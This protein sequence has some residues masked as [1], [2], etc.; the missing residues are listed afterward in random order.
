MRNEHAGTLAMIGDRL[1]G[2]VQAASIGMQALL[3]RRPRLTLVQ[4]LAAFPKD[5]PSKAP[6]RIHWNDHQIPF[7]DAKD[8]Q[9]LAVGLGMVHA[10][11][12]LAQME[13]MRRAAQGRIAEMVGPFGVEADR[14][15]RLLDVGRAVPAIAASLAPDT[16][17]W[18]EGFVR[19]VNHIQQTLR[20]LPEEMRLLRIGREPWTT[21][22]VLTNA[23]LA[24]AD[25]NW[26][27]YGALLR[28]RAAVPAEIWRS[29]WPKLT[30]GGMPN[31]E[32]KLAS[33]LAR[34]GSN[35]AA[36][37]G[38]R[39]ESG[40]AML[41]ADPHLSIALPNVWLAVC[42][43]S[44]GINVAG[45]MPAGLPIVAI[46]R[47]L[48]IAW[49]GTS[50]H[51]AASDLIDVADEAL[52][53]RLVTLRVRG[54]GTRKLRLRQ[55]RH[56]PV[57]SDGMMLR[58]T[59][60]LALRWVGHGVSD[61]I[62]AMFGVMRAETPDAFRR[63]L[64]SFAIPGQNMIYATKSGDIGHV[65]ALAAPRRA[66][67]PT[68]VVQTEAAAETWK[69]LAR[70]SEFPSHH[71]PPTGIVASANDEPPP[72]AVPAGFFFSPPD[73]VQRLRAMLGTE[74]K[75]GLDDLAL[76]Q[77]DT[78]G[79]TDAVRR[80]AARLPDHPARQ[81]LLSWDGR[82]DTGSEGAVVFETLMAALA[83]SLPDQGRVRALRAIW[84]GR[85][86]LAQEV[87]ALSDEEMRPLALRSM[88]R[89]LKIL[90][91]QGRWGMLHRMPIRHY[92]GAVP[93]AGWR[94]RFGDYG[95]AGGN[96]TLL[97]TGHGP[98][99]GRHLVTYGASARFLADMAKPDA[100]RVVLLGG[101]DGWLGSTTFADQTGV[102]RGGA[103]VDLP[104][105]LETARS[106]PHVTE[107]R[108]V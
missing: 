21:E 83:A 80:I 89:A 72:G 60:P 100:N 108:P 75:L 105:R 48:H 66:S 59:S 97:K 65:R 69:S 64:E 53:D 82:Y 107:L 70:I 26:V 13:I 95:A 2:A 37:A 27:V 90:R 7:I 24:A 39:S 54:A 8:D 10:H 106:W 57:V 18:I 16:R 91:R 6:V 85:R 55:S 98:V 63:A 81:I 99:T 15:L 35:A 1:I 23:R 104:L 92:F 17:A 101:Q 56:G 38:W 87:L 61:E 84:T 96:D 36:V 22:D 47:N 78:Q 49:G 71:N 79:R 31:P 5:A 43:R 58:H 9:D 44:P 30:A 94:Y 28:A 74:G 102:W 41:A 51:A 34:A 42:M 73:R 3:A 46:G 93:V 11:L 29:L 68:D 19:G 12:R 77:T 50:L 103:Y 45:L 86:L 20:T 25:V 33:A 40:S 62:G 52:E 67:V 32:G 76:T 4:R 14:A 88:D